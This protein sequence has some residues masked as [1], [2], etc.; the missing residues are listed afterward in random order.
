MVRSIIRIFVRMV[1]SNNILPSSPPACSGELNIGVPSTVPV[2]CGL[3]PV[4]RGINTSEESI[5]RVSL[6]QRTLLLAE[7]LVDM[8]SP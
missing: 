5:N 2:V 1:G 4:A 3:G 8:E 6:V 7:V